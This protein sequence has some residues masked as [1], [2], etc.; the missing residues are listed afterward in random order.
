MADSDEPQVDVPYPVSVKKP[1]G[2]LHGED[3]KAW[4]D[5]IAREINDSDSVRIVP[6]DD[7][8]PGDTSWQ[9]ATLWINGGCGGKLGGDGDED[10]D[11]GGDSDGDGD[12]G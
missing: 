4:L 8:D 10:G 5:Q 3:V 11:A 12:G 6:S 9:N 1:H 7:H 2:G